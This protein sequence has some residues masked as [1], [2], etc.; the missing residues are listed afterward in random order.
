MVTFREDQSGYGYSASLGNKLEYGKFKA[1]SQEYGRDAVRVVVDFLNGAY[2]GFMDLMESGNPVDVMKFNEGTL[3][4]VSRGM[5]VKPTAQQERLF[6]DTLRN[7]QIA[8]SAVL[9]VGGYP[10]DRDWETN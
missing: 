3:K 6:L 4:A 9:G 8:V 1:L 2:E 10:I 5:G 7:S